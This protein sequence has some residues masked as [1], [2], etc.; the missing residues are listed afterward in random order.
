MEAM[1]I[2]TTRLTL[3]QWKPEDK[4]PFY[5]LN[6]DPRV[7]EYFPAPLTLTESNDLADK[8]QNLIA[9]QGWGF[10]AV[11]LNE[12]QEF[13]GF[14]GLH[15]PKSDLPFSPCVEIG[16]RLA[17][18][19]WG[20]GYAFE[21]AKA[22]LEFGFTNLQLKEIVA[23]TT[24]YNKRSMAVMERL[25]MKWSEN[26]NHPHLPAGHDLSAHHLYRITSEQWRQQPLN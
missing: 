19:Y 21:A 6:S 3:R 14:V 23:F 11:E 18:R 22:S 8:I 4:A 9:E 10:W 26:F 2:K 13:I 24:L 1:E 20:K 7:M 25:G 17:C 16:W 15:I 12:T 5:E